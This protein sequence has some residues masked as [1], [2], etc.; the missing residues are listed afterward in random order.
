[1]IRNALAET[2][3]TLAIVFVVVALVLVPLAMT[4]ADPVGV[5]TTFL[6]GPFKSIRHI[7]NII[8]LATPSMF[9]GLA[10][11]LI[12][13]AGMFNLGV[14][15]AFFLGGLGTVAAALILPL[16]GPWLAPAALLAGAVIG[17]SVCV[18]PGVLR[19]R[20]G[21]SELVS[22]LM[23]NFAALFIGLYVLNVWLRDPAA[24]A[25]VSFKIPADARLPRL[26][27]GTRIHIGVLLA[28]AACGLG[29]LYLFRTAGGFESRI[30]GANPSFAAH[31][32]L[33]VA[34]IGLRAQILG[35][36]I[37]AFGGGIEM[38]GLYQRFSWQA[39]PG[40]GWTGVTV[41][42]L[43]RDHPALVIPAALFLGWLQV[44]GDLV[45]RNFDIPNEAVGLMQA[46][47][48]VTVTAAALTRNPRLLRAF[49]AR[50]PGAA[51]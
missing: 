6:F 38:L 44:G 27:E 47:L 45:A 33:D 29:A 11:A 2:A 16:P 23:L 22:S 4:Q 46:L 17:S 3:L 5:V 31:L 43:A 8:E 18:V 30:A 39:L 28:L 7:G 14:E 24:G 10:V 19:A 34:R 32:G 25:M 36:L 35:G 49:G 50:S 1:M 42:I 13:R 12:L 20:Y 15:G 37:A 41:A 9:C 40:N 48:L 51:R 26:I 21:A